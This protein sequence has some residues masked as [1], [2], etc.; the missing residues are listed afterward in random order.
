MLLTIEKSADLV[1]KQPITECLFWTIR[2][3]MAGPP[4]LGIVAAYQCVLPGEKLSRTV[5]PAAAGHFRGAG[6]PPSSM[7][8]AICMMGTSSLPRTGRGIATKMIA[9]RA[10]SGL[11]SCFPSLPSGCRLR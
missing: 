2:T 4:R 8:G 3:W 9:A 7:S 1:T 5:A 11:I 6:E 10:Q